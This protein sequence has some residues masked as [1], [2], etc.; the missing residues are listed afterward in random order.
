MLKDVSPAQAARR[1]GITL[2]AVYKLIYADK[3]T[4]K[5]VGTRWLVPLVAVEAR[6]KAREERYATALR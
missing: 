5:K 3:L 6:L 2:D 4:A 1:L